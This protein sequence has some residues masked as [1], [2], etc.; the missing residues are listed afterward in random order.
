MFFFLEIL[1]FNYFNEC[2]RFFGIFI[3]KKRSHFSLKKLFTHFLTNFV[4]FLDQILSYFDYF[5]IKI[6][7]HLVEF[8]M[9]KI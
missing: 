8:F 3:K 9:L 7:E 5:F 2:V 1:H 4:T 6:E